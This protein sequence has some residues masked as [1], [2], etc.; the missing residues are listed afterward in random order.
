MTATGERCMG[1]Y[2]PDRNNNFAA[3]DVTERSARG[4]G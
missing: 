4:G 3:A 2:E 1:K